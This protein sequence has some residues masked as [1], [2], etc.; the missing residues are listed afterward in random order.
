MASS[1]HLLPSNIDKIN[2]CINI[3]IYRYIEMK[4]MIIEW[5]GRKKRKQRQWRRQQ[6]QPRPS[7]DYLFCRAKTCTFLVCQQSWQ[8]DRTTHSHMPEDDALCLSS[9]HTPRHTV[10]VTVTVT[11][12][13]LFSFNSVACFYLS[14]NIFLLYLLPF[15][16]CTFSTDS[17]KR[18]FCSTHFELTRWLNCSSLL[19]FALNLLYLLP[20]YLFFFVLLPNYDESEKVV[21]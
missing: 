8:L 4:W 10:A 14:G 2:I 1:Q 16:Y 20:K 3:N 19:L 12:W 17:L 6:Q 11:Q 7:T 21:Q 13:I 18:F 9:W 5:N 15:P